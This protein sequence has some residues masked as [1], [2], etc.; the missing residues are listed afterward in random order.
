MKYI[1]NRAA[2]NISS[3]ANQTIVP[4]LTKL[5]RSTAPWGACPV[6]TAVAVATAAIIAVAGSA[7]ASGGI[8]R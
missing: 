5:G 1:A 4:M 8:L 6:S 3:D 7:R 2:K